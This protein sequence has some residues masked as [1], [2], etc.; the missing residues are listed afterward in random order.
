MVLCRRNALILSL[1]FAFGFFTR[2][3]QY[4]YDYQDYANDYEDG[5]LY[6]EYADR[7]EQKAAG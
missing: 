1:L 5:N 7:Q 3:Q 4:D 6:Q 2:A